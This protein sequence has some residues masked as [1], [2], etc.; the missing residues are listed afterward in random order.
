MPELKE[1]IVF[2]SDKK[3]YT[4]VFTSARRKELMDGS[5]I[6][7]PGVKIVF[8]KG[9]YDPNRPD[10]LFDNDPEKK[11]AAILEAMIK[12][13]NVRRY[14]QVRYPKREALELEATRVAAV[15]ES[16]EYK[17]LQVELAEARAG[18]INTE[19]TEKEDGKPRT[20]VRGSKKQTRAKA[21]LK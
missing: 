8:D 10:G 14:V 3:E 9:R 1:E 7:S 20:S 2:Y 11:V 21:N 4:L 18:R 6:E 12:D 16:P 13:P 15:E 19:D 17:A 5:V